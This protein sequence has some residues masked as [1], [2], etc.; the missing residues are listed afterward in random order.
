VVPGCCCCND[1][2][3]VAVLEVVAMAGVVSSMSTSS[4]SSD[5]PAVGCLLA[6]P[7]DLSFVSF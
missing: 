2:V 1:C 7:L 6:L 3:G 5:S 4:S